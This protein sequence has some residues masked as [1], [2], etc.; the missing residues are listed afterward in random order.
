[1]CIV[2]GELGGGAA[3]A[4]VFLLVSRE[5]ARAARRIPASGGGRIVHITPT[6]VSTTLPGYAADSLNKAAVET[7]TKIVAKEVAEEKT[8]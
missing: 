3:V 6:V 7:S 1:V 4:A 2:V 8:E 5:A